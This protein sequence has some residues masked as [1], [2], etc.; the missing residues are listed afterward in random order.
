MKGLNLF[1]F[2]TEWQIR[3]LKLWILAPTIIWAS[4]RTMDLALT[5]SERW[6]AIMVQ[7]HVPVDKNLVSLAL[8]L[9]A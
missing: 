3:R 4:Q 5:L 2:S 7:Q 1:L 9:Q 8:P 6:S